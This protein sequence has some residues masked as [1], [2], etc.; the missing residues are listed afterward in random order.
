MQNS[1]R[2]FFKKGSQ[3]SLVALSLGVIVLFGQSVMYGMN[4]TYK[5]TP[6]TAQNIAS[7]AHELPSNDK[8]YLSDWLE[9]YK[10]PL[11]EAANLPVYGDQQEVASRLKYIAG[12]LSAYKLNNKSNCNFVFAVDVPNG[13]K[14][15]AVKF[16]GPLNRRSTYNAG[17]GK[18]WGTIISKEYFEEELVK[19]MPETYQGISRVAHALRL[20]EWR[21]KYKN[22]HGVEAPI[23]G[24]KSSVLYL[25]G[26]PTTVAD[27]N[28]VVVEEIFDNTSSIGENRENAAIFL[29]AREVFKSALAYVGIWAVNDRDYHVDNQNK[30]IVCIDM[31]QPGNSKPSDFFHKNESKYKWNI[32]VGYDELDETCKKLEKKFFVQSDDKTE[33][34]T[35]EKKS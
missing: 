24:P 33:E 29:K 26:R 30:T 9:K 12:V 35:E 20:E 32:K 6:I 14:S 7:M 1:Y 4:N 16:A 31:E 34:K 15:Y 22:E 19:K 27:G 13:D 18:A 17:D 28:C 2:K 21:E 11:V 23:K 3:G 25:P 8:K 10:E 5:G